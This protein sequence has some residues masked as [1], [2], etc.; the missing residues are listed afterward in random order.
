MLTL[1]SDFL[2][3]EQSMKSLPHTPRR[4]AEAA[5]RCRQ[6]VVQGVGLTVKDG[7][8]LYQHPSVP[9]LPHR[10]QRTAQI[11]AGLPDYFVQLLPLSMMP[12]QEQTIP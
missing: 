5:L 10:V 6:G 9:G 8:Q 4:E 7:Y 1:Q 11:R 2:R 3:E 12:L